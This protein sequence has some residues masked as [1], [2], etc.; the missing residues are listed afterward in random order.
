MR[1]PGQRHSICGLSSEPMELSPHHPFSRRRARVF[2]SKTMAIVCA[3]QARQRDEMSRKGEMQVHAFS[4]LART[5]RTKAMITRRR[6]ARPSPPAR[7]AL[8][9]HTQQ[10]RE[11]AREWRSSHT[12]L[13]Q[14]SETRDQKSAH[15]DDERAKKCLVRANGGRHQNANNFRT[16]HE[17]SRKQK[18][19]RPPPVSSPSLHHHHQQSHGSRTGQD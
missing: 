6:C 1:R 18:T 11:C 9:V 4:S 13:M 2:V 7:L 3:R 19:R 10:C 15:D 14:T 17:L 12:K 16:L 5:A 8:I